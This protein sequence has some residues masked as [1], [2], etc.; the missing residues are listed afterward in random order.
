MSE[1]AYFE[2]WSKRT[3]RGLRWFWHCKSNGNHRIVFSGEPNGYHNRVDA[4]HGINFARLTTGATPIKE[5]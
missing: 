5:L 1:R 3:W 4:I 2:L